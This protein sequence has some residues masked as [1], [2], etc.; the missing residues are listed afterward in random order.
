MLGAIV[1]L[2]NKSR[3]VTDYIRPDGKWEAVTVCAC[4]R[5][6]VRGVCQWKKRLPG[7]SSALTSFWERPNSPSNGLPGPLSTRGPLITGDGL[8]G[9][10][11]DFLLKILPQHLSALTF[12]GEFCWEKTSLCTSKILWLNARMIYVWNLS[13][14]KKNFNNIP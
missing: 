6:H 5:A 11:V 10:L 1:T 4:A 2:G 13:L 14:G 9:N 3:R 12:S 8:W 7:S